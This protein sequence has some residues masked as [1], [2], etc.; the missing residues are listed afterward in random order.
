MPRNRQQERAKR[1]NAGKENPPHEPLAAVAFQLRVTQKWTYEQIA[2]KLGI[3]KST[4]HGYCQRYASQVIRDS[5]AKLR[6]EQAMVAE[7]LI[8]AASKLHELWVQSGYLDHAHYD[9]WRQ[10]IVDYR[11][12]LGLDSEKGLGRDTGAVE[13]DRYAGGAAK[14]DMLEMAI[15]VVTEQP[16]PVKLIESRMVTEG[17][18]V[19]E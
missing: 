7:M 5:Q 17:E 19:A 14:M 16:N 1:Q 10:T 3:S 8:S 9:R 4:A 6:A 12:L 11:Q 13:E 2:K 18:D 15:M